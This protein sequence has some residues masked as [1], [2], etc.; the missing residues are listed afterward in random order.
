MRRL[1]FPFSG[2]EFYLEG[3]SFHHWI[4]VNRAQVGDEIEISDEEGKV[5]VAKLEVIEENRGLLQVVRE[6]ELSP[7]SEVKIILGI[8]LLKGEKMDWLIQKAV[9]IGVAEIWPLE[10]DHSIVKLDS[11]KSLERQK[12]WQKIALEA[13]Q[14]CGGRLIPIV[15][16]PQ[17]LSVAM[18]KF[19]LA[20]VVWVP[21][22]RGSD[23]SFKKELRTREKVTQ[24][25]I[26]IGPEGGFSEK[27]TGFLE[28]LSNSSLI[29]LGERIL[30]AE[31]AALVS[32]SLLRYEWD[33][34]GGQE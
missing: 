30:R 19:S 31:T 1:F 16:I 7:Q 25:L 17:K 4:R 28:A 2:I 14:Q 12:R 10:L 26:V 20:G 5:V 23:N 22:E 29:T 3:E 34:L 9:E 33:D 24:N 15:K 6:V 18:E 11:K 13:S 27:E 32:L 21:H 8:G